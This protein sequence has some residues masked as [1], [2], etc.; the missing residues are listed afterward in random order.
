MKKIFAMRLGAR[1][2]ACCALGYASFSPTVFAGD[3]LGCEKPAPSVTSESP[4]EASARRSGARIRTATERVEATPATI[5]EAL[6]R[7]GGEAR[8][9]CSLWAD[10]EFE[11]FEQSTYKEPFADG[12]YIVNGDMAIA[13]HQRLREFFESRIKQAPSA[14]ALGALV[15]HKAGSKDAVW[16][17]AMRKRLT[18]CVSNTFGERR[19]RVVDDME[20]ATRA[21]EE[22]ADVDFIHLEAEDADCTPANANVVFDVRPV[23]VDGQYLARAFFPNED[24]VERNLLIDES[25]FAMPADGVLQLVGILRHELG[26]ALGW[27]HEHTRPESGTCFEDNNWR[28]LTAYDRFSVM[29]YPQCNGGGDWSLNL[30]DLDKNGAAC[31]YGAAPGFQIDPQVCPQGG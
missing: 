7:L 6:E 17:A 21:W 22:A 19:P 12:K 8:E 2:L 31:V 24:R 23:E 20:A 14:P 1:V 11:E 27:R 13:D 4:L 18:Y 16:D 29:H 28:P 10:K 30:T 3:F 26:H 9:Q 5:A 15:V 25:A